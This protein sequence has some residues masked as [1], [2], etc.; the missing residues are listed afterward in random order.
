MGRMR[1]TVWSVAS[2]IFITIVTYDEAIL[3]PFG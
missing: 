2:V 3:Q 1:I